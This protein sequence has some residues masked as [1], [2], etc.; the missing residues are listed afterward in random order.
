MNRVQTLF[1]SKSHETEHFNFETSSKTVR[2]QKQRAE[3]A[4][5]ETLLEAI[6]PQTKSSIEA[7]PVSWPVVDHTCD[8]KL[9]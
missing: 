8:K 5:E 6:T 9:D 1:K 4:F 2:S 7:M 3:N